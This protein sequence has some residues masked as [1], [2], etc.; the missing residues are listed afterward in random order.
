MVKRSMNWLIYIC[1]FLLALFVIYIYNNQKKPLKFIHITKTGGTSIEDVGKKNNIEWGR[2]HKEYG[3]WHKIFINKS[4][5]L[6]N[7][8]D[9][10]V[11]VRNPYDRMLSEYY[12]KWGGIGNRPHTKED[13]NRYLIDKINNRNLEGDHYTEQY[14]Y[15]DNSTTIHILHF[16]NLNDD[17]MQLMNSYNIKVDALEQTNVG[18]K[19]YNTNDFNEELIHLINTVY[20]NDFEQF[21]YSMM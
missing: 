8:F 3:P 13:M 11:V 15:I 9:W 20:K 6:K 4:D 2:F 14:K 12:C 10:F 18:N 17:F 7:K 1:L 16:E 21:G 19:Q 5:E